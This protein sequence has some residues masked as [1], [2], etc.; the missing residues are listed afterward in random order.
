MIGG[1]KEEMNLEVSSELLVEGLEEILP[2]SLRIDVPDDAA[3]GCCA[4]G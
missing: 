4:V 3:L 2:V 1:E